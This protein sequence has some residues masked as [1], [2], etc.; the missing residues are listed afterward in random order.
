MNRTQWMR[1][2]V[3][4]LLFVAVGVA[5]ADWAGAQGRWRQEAERGVEEDGWRA[6]YSTELTEQ[7]A[8]RGEVAPGISIFAARGTMEMMRLHDWANALIQQAAG[9]AGISGLDQNEQFQTMRF[10]VR[11]VREL[12]RG[13]RSGDGTLDVNGLEFKAGVLERRGRFGRL[14]VPYVALR[15][16][17]AQ[18]DWRQQDSTPWQQ[19]PQLPA[20]AP[21]QQEQFFPDASAEPLNAFRL[22]NTARQI[23][24]DRWEWTAFID[25]PAPFLR[26]IRSV[27]YHLHSTFNPSRRQGDSTRL[28]HPLTAVGWGIFL[29][30]ADVELDDGT[31]R[32]YEHT[33]Q[34]H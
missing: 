1:A 13:P 10:T 17:A 9:V 12:L 6:A 14:F 16:A 7:E 28:G 32:S 22:T 27:T 11:T 19:A 26:R 5:A 24:G 33:L 20:T 4:L 25:G 30:R 18:R 34:F 8:G 29:L 23:S 15:S 2:A 21:Q 3:S 31:Q